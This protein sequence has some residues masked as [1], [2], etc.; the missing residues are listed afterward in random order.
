LNAI[1]LHGVFPM[2][3]GISFQK[4]SADDKKKPGATVRRALHYTV[5]N[6]LW[7]GPVVR[8]VVA[9]IA[10][11][12]L[13][14]LVG[15]I[16]GGSATALAGGTVASAGISLIVRLILS[17]GSASAALARTAARAPIGLIIRRILTGRRTLAA[18]AWAVIRAGVA[19]FVVLAD[20]ERQV[21][22]GL[23]P[24]DVVPSGAA[25]IRAETGTARAVIAGTIIVWPIR[26]TMIAP[27]LPTPFVA[28]P[29]TTIVIVEI[30]AP[31]RTKAVGAS[32]RRPRTAPL[33]VTP[34]A[35]DPE[36]RTALGLTIVHRPPEPVAAIE[37]RAIVY[38]HVPEGIGTTVIIAISAGGIGKIDSAR[39]Y[40][41]GKALRICRS[42]PKDCRACQRGDGYRYLC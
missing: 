6:G 10:F 11:F 13:V 29:E 23:V 41:D 26:S 19:V 40:A 30:E 37:N 35:A 16:A 12:A 24:V 14:W 9:F 1:K 15:L 18:G 22:T 7:I 36:L 27:S 2:Q 31:R 38:R 3:L 33:I 21:Q 8:P 17:K 34:A 25:S 32:P 4:N 39:A 5:F 20:T 28:H 42:S